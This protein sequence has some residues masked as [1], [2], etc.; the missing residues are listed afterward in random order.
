MPSTQLGHFPAGLAGSW[1]QGR[2]LGRALLLAE[3]QLHKVV[4]LTSLTS[5]RPLCCLPA[6]Q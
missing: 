4:L 6:A 1:Q 5:Q 2:A 3:L